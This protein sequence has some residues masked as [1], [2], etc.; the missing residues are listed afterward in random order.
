MRRK[1]F[2]WTLGVAGVLAAPGARASAQVAPP[3]TVI[4]RFMDLDGAGGQFTA[5]GWQVIAPLF[6]AAVKPEH[7]HFWVVTEAQPTKSEEIHGDKA[8]VGIWYLLL[9]E[10]DL[11]QLKLEPRINVKM[12]GTL[13][14]RRVDGQWK[15]EGPV[16]EPRLELEPAIRCITE[17]RARTK[18]QAV[19]RNATNT[20][21]WL[22]G[23]RK[24]SASH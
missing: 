1:S 18:D 6:V 11:E 20:L 5:V 23:F 17:L 21:V 9:A 3:H 22:K 7:K 19:R 4:E 2:I 24:A 13:D 14:L 12:R 16:P 8:V 10:I 15:I